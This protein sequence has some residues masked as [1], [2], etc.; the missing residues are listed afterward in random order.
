M[1]RWSS[2]STTFRSSFVHHV[3]GP[4]SCGSRRIPAERK[5]HWRGFNET[6]PS[7]DVSLVLPAGTISNP[8]L[9]Y[10]PGATTPYITGNPCTSSSESSCGLV[11]GAVGS[12]GLGLVA[13]TRAG[14]ARL[15]PEILGIFTGSDTRLPNASRTSLAADAER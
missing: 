3:R 15:E 8:A 6:F 14:G 13:R 9:N 5:R 10:G 12:T 4:Y 11:R 1:T 2:R 7:G